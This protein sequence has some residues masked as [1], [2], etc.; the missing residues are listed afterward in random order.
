MKAF[1]SDKLAAAIN[2]YL[3]LDP[4]SHLR[5][6]AL[7][8]KVVTLELLGMGLNLQ[9]IF[10]AGKVTLRASEFEDACTHIK[11]TPITLLRMVLTQGDRKHF[12]ADDV[13][14]EGDLEVGQDVIDLFDHIE[15]DWE[16]Y[17]SRWMGDMPAH[18]VGNVVREI[19]KMSQR[20][21]EVLLQNV[22][23]YVHEEKQLVPPTEE[24]KDFFADVDELRMDVDRLE[25]RIQTLKKQNNGANI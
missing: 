6:K 25:A 2:H 24:L 18:Q 1:F 8:G 22:N 17:L 9:L 16:E 5:L 20:T 19:K 10:Q 11:G 21:R 14:I 7:E 3:A 4:E 12:F 23:E 15:I 13:T